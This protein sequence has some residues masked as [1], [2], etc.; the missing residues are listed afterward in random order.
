[1]GAQVKKQEAPKEKAASQ[2]RGTPAFAVLKPIHK[3]SETETDASG[4]FWAN[5]I[6]YSAVKL[7]HAPLLEDSSDRLEILELLDD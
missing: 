7:P 6:D 4:H 2:A 3:S 1:M 5:G